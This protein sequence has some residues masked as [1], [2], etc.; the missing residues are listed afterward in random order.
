MILIKSFVLFCAILCVLCNRKLQA[1][2][3]PEVSSVAAALKKILVDIFVPINKTINVVTNQLQYPRFAGLVVRRMMENYGHLMNFEI[4]NRGHNENEK[5]D[6]YE[7]TKIFILDHFVEAAQVFLRKN[8][9]VYLFYISGMTSQDY[10]QRL[11]EI[12][13]RNERTKSLPRVLLLID[14]G[15][16]LNLKLL[17][18][19]T[20]TSCTETTLKIINRFSKVSQ[21]WELPTFD[22]KQHLKF[23][24]CA[25]MTSCFFTGPPE[26]TKPVNFTLSFDEYSG[27]F[28]DIAKELARRF[29]FKMSVSQSYDNNVIIFQGWATIRT[30]RKGGNQ[31]QQK[32]LTAINRYI[33][34]LVPLGDY[35]TGLEKLFLPYD[36]IGWILIVLTF[37]G[38][39]IV[40][41][42]VVRLSKIKQN[43]VFG[44]RVSSPTMNLFAAFFGFGQIVLPGRNFARFILMLYIIWCLII[45]TAYQGILYE[46]LKSDGRKPQSWTIENF[47]EGNYLEENATLY[48]N[49]ISG[50]W[51]ED[52][53]I[54]E[55]SNA[56]TKIR[57]ILDEMREK[58]SVRP[59]DE[60]N[61]HER[62]EFVKNSSGE[63]FMIIDD[64]QFAISNQKK[65]FTGTKILKNENIRLPLKFAEVAGYFMHE[66]FEAKLLQMQEAG[67]IEYWKRKYYDPKYLDLIPEEIE[68]KVL[69]VEQLSIG[70]QVFL[71]FSGAAIAVFVIEIVKFKWQKHRDS[72]RVFPF[73]N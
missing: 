36:L 67:L 58:K 54:I 60:S 73:L 25:L 56:T 22:L 53:Y 72:R 26:I 46:F 15:D 30:T 33:Y 63:H 48:F 68:P 35:Y 39:L 44:R 3:D 38:G 61:V 20:A 59:Y 17:T 45:R 19:F 41:Q 52:W 50:Q 7:R 12:D 57:H 65:A 14:E 6:F 64:L 47:L 37:S 11:M 70:F 42:V 4:E 10:L 55:F 62:F 49:E 21:Q 8:E 32:Y 51:L 18:Y 24:G 40:I 43:F 34:F 1:I 27:Y 28:A 66:L 29:N 2:E 13:P 69:T 23:Q 71:L 5:E 31:F 16:Y 9:M